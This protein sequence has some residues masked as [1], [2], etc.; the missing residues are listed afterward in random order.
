MF[1]SVHGDVKL[2]D[3]GIAKTQLR[4]TRP[5]KGDRT[6]GKLGYLSPEQVSGRDSDQRADLFA[7]AVITTEML[8]GRPLFAGG[9]EI[10][11]LLAIR[12]GNIHTFHEHAPELPKE[13]V[14][15]IER[16]LAR[17]PEERTATAG[18]LREALE[19]WV[20]APVEDL[21]KQLGAL[22]ADALAEE[23][24]H[25]SSDRD[26][27]RKTVEA[28]ISTLS[29]PPSPAAPTVPPPPNYEDQ[30]DEVVHPKM[31]VPAGAYRVKTKDRARS[32]SLH[33]RADDRGDQ[34]RRGRGCRSGTA[35]Q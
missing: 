33:L 5:K 7:A 24:R 31:T 1:L 23:A 29:A 21:R 12:D 22:V 16:G 20:T 19:P 10:A 18:E 27:L 2:G 34:D 8:M 25:V 30:V 35:G 4:T 17:D 28:D 14:A 3:L 11:I 15:A 13:V 6:K 26:S 9:S 32:G